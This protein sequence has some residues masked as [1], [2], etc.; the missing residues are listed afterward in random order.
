MRSGSVRLRS[1][2]VVGLLGVALTGCSGLPFI[3]ASPLDASANS[4]TAG[5]TAAPLAFNSVF[6]DMGSVHEKLT[7]ANELTLDLDMWTEQKTRDWTADSQKQFSFVVTVVD[8]AVPVDALFATKR[9]AYLSNLTVT[10]TTTTTSGAI[11]TPLVLT[12]DPITATLDPEA[13]KSSYGLLITSPKG[14]FQL[15]SNT[16]G[17]VA[18]DT[19]GITLDFALTVSSESA[20]VSGSYA[21]QVIHELVPVAIY[22]KS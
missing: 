21:T 12:I 7:V 3:G 9:L 16:V 8:G 6:S 18:S 20:P 13:L 4:A 15:D 10:V 17:Q 5:A 14:G 11:Q 1:A 22:P 2:L 19:T